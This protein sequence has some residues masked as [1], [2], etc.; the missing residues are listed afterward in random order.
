MRLFTVLTA[1]TVS[2]LSA[3]LRAADENNG[4]NEDDAV[5]QAVSEIAQLGQGVHQVRTDGNGRIKCMAQF[6]QV[7]IAHKLG[8][9]LTRMEAE[10]GMTPSA[11]TRIEV[12]ERMEYDPM[13]DDPNSFASFLKRAKETE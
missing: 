12:T 2:L 3:S 6:P 13:L 8:M 7:S 9:L 10:F 11:R 5:S 1:L 4:Q